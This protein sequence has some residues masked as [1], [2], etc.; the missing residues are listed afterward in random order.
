MTFIKVDMS[1]A[2]ASLNQAQ[3]SLHHVPAKLPIAISRAINRA[4]HAGRACAVREV[5]KEYTIKAGAVRESMSLSLSNKGELVG[6]IMSRGRPRS[7][8]QFRLSPKRNTTGGN[9]KQ[10]L[11]AVR[12]GGPLKP[13]GQFVYQGK[14]FSRVGSTCLPIE[15]KVGPAVPSLLKN[16]EIKAAVQK[17]IVSTFSKRLD[18]E[19]VRILEAESKR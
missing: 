19:M 11:V 16:A 4:V 3:I 9:R 17:T 6:A 12:K 8:S 7:F 18:H 10:P 2:Q 14:V 15:H 1:G 13:L 5:R